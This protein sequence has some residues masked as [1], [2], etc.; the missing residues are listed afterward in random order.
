MGT[1]EGREAVEM[2]AAQD[3]TGEAG[4]STRLQSSA[5]AV[6]ACIPERKMIISTQFCDR[7]Q[8]HAI[9]EKSVCVCMR[10]EWC[11]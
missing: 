4:A 8:K 9:P 5:H 7:G 6:G 11:V 1:T 10:G 2:T 3:V